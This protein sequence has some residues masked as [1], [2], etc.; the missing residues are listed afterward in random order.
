MW[1]ANRTKSMKSDTSKPVTQH[2]AP[3][4]EPK[5]V[6]SSNARAAAR[7]IEEIERRAHELAQ[8]ERMGQAARLLLRAARAEPQELAR[9]LQ[10]ARWQRQNREPQAAAETLLAALRFNHMSDN[11]GNGNTKNTSGRWSAAGADMTQ[12]REVAT[13]AKRASPQNRRAA[14][15]RA[16]QADSSSPARDAPSRAD[17]PNTSAANTSAARSE[18]LPLW[19]A[20][21]EAQL[22]A[23][24][25]NGAIEACRELLKNEPRHH[26]GREMLAT[27]L[28]H[29]G[30]IDEAARVMRELL[31]LSPR[32]PLHRLKF[33]TL[34]QLQGKSGQSSREFQRV[35]DSHPDAPFVDE[36][37]DAIETLDHIQI[38]QVL[39]R[40]SE[41]NAF[42]EQLENSFESALPDNGFHLSESGRESLRHILGDGRP[43]YGFGTPPRVH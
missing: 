18:C 21:A 31:L 20:L 34:L 15:L 1:G 35:A 6:D 8:S 28:L 36:A 17:D 12:N 4:T 7:S 16:A 11:I 38:Q 33:A 19:Q 27:A 40:A 5:A 25:W 23:Q 29:S 43:D 32:D 30:R 24:N 26:F 10:I 42:R 37:H 41:E 13:K 22:E 9:W 2:V 39:I 14:P 3:T